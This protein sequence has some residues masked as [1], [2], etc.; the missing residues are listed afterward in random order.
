MITPGP[1]VA[2]LYV[3]TNALLRRVETDVELSRAGSLIT[4]SHFPEFHKLGSQVPR[5]V[6]VLSPSWTRVGC[7]DI[8]APDLNTSLSVWFRGLWSTPN[9]YPKTPDPFS[10]KSLCLM[11]GISRCH[12]MPESRSTTR[13]REKIRPEVGAGRDRDDRFHFCTWEQLRAPL[14]DGTTHSEYKSMAAGFVASSIRR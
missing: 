13:K 7:L 9:S 10:P 11:L 14:V 5:L 3:N 12:E 4:G 1:Q 2:Y 6:T 8:H